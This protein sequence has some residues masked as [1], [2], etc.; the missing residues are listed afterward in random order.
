MAITEYTI[1]ASISTTE[2]SVT[3]NTGSVQAQTGDGVVQAF[4]DFSAMAAGD[5][6]QVR[7]YEKVRSASTQRVVYEAVLTGAQDEIFVTPALTVMHGWDVTIDKLAGTDRTIE[8]SVRL[9]PI[10]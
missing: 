6:F 9:I 1:N 3:G 10:A 7:I 2:Y 5:Q 4:F 8:A